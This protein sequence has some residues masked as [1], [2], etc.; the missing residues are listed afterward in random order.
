MYLLL[1][2]VFFA[3]LCVDV[4]VLYGASGFS[5]FNGGIERGLSVCVYVFK[6]E[7]FLGIYIY[8]CLDL[9]QYIF[10]SRL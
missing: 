1:L 6:G 5:C 8:L 9:A 10:F 2:V 4:C 3:Q 7:L